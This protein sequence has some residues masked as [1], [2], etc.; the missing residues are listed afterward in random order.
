MKLSL[1]ILGVLLVLCCSTVNSAAPKLINYQGRLTASGGSPV[2]D[3][4]YTVRF[5]VYADSTTSTALWEETQPVQVTNGLFAVVLGGSTAL[6][7]T[8]FNGQDRFLGTKVNL[9]SEVSPRT[10]LLSVPFALETQQWSST[11]G[12]VG[13][14]GRVGIGMTA[15]THKLDVFDSSGAYWAGRFGTNNPEASFLELRNSGV[16]R[17]WQIGI[18]GPNG[19]FSSTLK[20]N[21]FY[22]YQPPLGSIPFVID[23]V[24]H[25]GI[26]FPAPYASPAAA[27]AVRG[28]P[29]PISGGYGDGIQVSGSG[30][31]SYALYASS[32]TADAAFFSGNVQIGGTLSKT[33][34]SFK[35]DHPLDPANK[36]LSHSFVESPD[37]MN[38][39]NGNV[40]TDAGGNA[41]VELPEW[42]GALNKDFRYQLTVLGQFAQAI[43][44]QKVAN[45]RFSIKTDKP[46]VE[47]SWMVTGIRQDA[48]ANAHRIPVEEDKPAKEKGHYQFPELFGQPEEKGV[49]WALR[50]E[51]MQQMKAEREMAKE[52]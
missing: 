27:L 51:M 15:P 32:T 26:N 6:P 9:D 31:G 13:R 34:G 7:D 50:P 12:G 40:T 41:T 36:Y 19:A 11:A 14:S 37:M 10:R 4:I 43:V 17:T 23:S 45:N 3:G 39:Y 29:T 8:L 21:G 52:R 38:I 18:T 42:F 35:I 44:S 1:T 2:T 16:S 20:P 46:N 28:Q 48:Y 22:I 25:V 24:G 30:G 49:T 33:A 5:R 47:V